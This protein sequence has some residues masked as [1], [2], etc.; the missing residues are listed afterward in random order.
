MSATYSVTVHGDEKP[1]WSGLDEVGLACVRRT[2]EDRNW[3]YTVSTQ[4]QPSAGGS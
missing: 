2:C 3:Q 1:T 4:T